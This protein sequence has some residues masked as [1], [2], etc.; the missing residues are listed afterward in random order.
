MHVHRT[1]LARRLGLAAG[2][3]AAVAAGLALASPAAAARPGSASVANDTLTV[4]GTSAN[5]RIALRLEA[6]GSNNLQ[7]DFGD[8]LTAEFTFDRTTFSKIEI[9]ARSGSDA[10]RIDQI[11]G[12]FGDEQTTVDGGSGDDSFNGGDNAELF[13]G[14]SGNDF[15]DGN[16]GDDTAQMGSGS[17]T[18]RWDPGDDNDFI[19]GQSGTDTLDFNGAGAAER[20]SLEPNGERALF[21][22]DVANVRM[23]MDG[24]ER[25]DLAALGG[26]D[27]MTVEDMTGT[28]FRQADVDLRGAT[29]APDLA[30]DIVI[31]N[32][33]NRA[34]RVNVVAEAGRVDV[35]G[36][37]TEVRIP[38]AEL[39]DLLQVNTLDGNDVVNVAAAAQALITV[40]VDL[41]AG[42]I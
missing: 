32:G 34:D 13:I 41:G 16:N 7:V 30:A 1:R 12:A 18:F 14:G 20:M 42:Q 39:I 36:L 6:P 9:S 29:G 40:A 10:I 11:N 23:D 4:N 25:L 24:V 3:F 17:D 2:A 15:N 35:E 31:V 21:L 5:D 28:D 27:T 33:T 22:R 26:A 8:D 19:E 37:Q 38:G